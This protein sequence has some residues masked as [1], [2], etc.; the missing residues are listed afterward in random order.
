MKTTPELSVVHE[1]LADRPKALEFLI[2][3]SGYCALA[4]DIADGDREPRAVVELCAVASSLYNC[5]YWRT[6]GRELLIA[7]RLNA[8]SFHDSLRLEQSSDGCLVPSW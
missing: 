7:E 6:Y 5:E 8:L 1:L 3:Y 2:L 4:D